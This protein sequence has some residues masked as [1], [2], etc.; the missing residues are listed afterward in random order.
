MFYYAKYAAY[1][2]VAV[3]KGFWSTI[4]VWAFQWPKSTIKYPYEKHTKLKASMPW[5]GA[6]T[7]VLTDDGIDKCDGCS[8]CSIVCPVHCI[9]VERGVSA[10][11]R[12]IPAIYMVD[13]S[14]CSYCHLCTE[15]CPQDALRETDT[16]AW[17]FEKKP[18]MVLGKEQMTVKES[19]EAWLFRGDP[20]K[21][22][23]P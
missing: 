1:S 10:D 9:T 15:W 13:F 17:T 4:R 6:Q 21:S 20:V 12:K 22:Q 14:K 16:V 18:D 11:G 23:R 3:A 19:Q 2:A 5:R 7:L 8:I